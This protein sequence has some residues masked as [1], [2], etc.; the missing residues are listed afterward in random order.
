MQFGMPTLIELKEAEPCAALC[1][2]LELDFVELSMDM[3]EYQEEKFDLTEL[4]DI[5]KKYDISYTIH[6]EGFLDPCVFNKR[7]ASAYTETALHMIEKAKQLGV[8]V[9]N[10]HMNRGDHFTLPDRRVALYNEYKAEYLQKLFDFR[11]ACIEAIGSSDIKICLE[12]CGDYKQCAFMEDGLDV[13]LESP[14]FSLT[15]DIGH[16]A[17]GGFTDEPIIMKR[18]NRLHHM[19]I[20]DAMADEKRDHMTLGEGNL[21]LAK[22]LGLAKE[23]DCNA[24]LEVKTIDGLRKSVSWLKKRGYL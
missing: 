2:E 8:P 11:D 7:V 16:N 4:R 17:G 14:A 20:H 21:D 9:L 5:A 19:H 13:L 12:N 3:P 6:L 23:Y 24:V 1:H 22:Y 18:A 10:M 15:F